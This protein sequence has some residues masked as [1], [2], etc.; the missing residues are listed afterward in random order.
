MPHTGPDTTVFLLQF[1]YLIPTTS[2][3]MLPIKLCWI[4]VNYIITIAMS[5]TH[6]RMFQK[7]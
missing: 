5:Q 2:D 1:C 6:I 7:D 4:N 3:L